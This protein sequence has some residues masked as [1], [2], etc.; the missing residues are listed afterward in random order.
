MA[1]TTLLETARQCERLGVSTSE[2]ASQAPLDA[3]LPMDS[4]DSSVSAALLPGAAGVAGAPAGARPAAAAP[5][6]AADACSPRPR[7]G[8]IDVS[9]MFSVEGTARH[10]S[11]LISPSTLG[12]AG[13]PSG[14]TDVAA[15]LGSPR[16]PLPQQ[17]QE[18]QQQQQ[19]RQQQQQQQ[20]GAAPSPEQQQERQQ[21][22]GVHASGLPLV[23]SPVDA[24]AYFSLEGATRE[25]GTLRY[26]PAT[27]AGSGCLCAC[28]PACLAG[29]LLALACRCP[30]G[31]SA[32][33]S[34]SLHNWSAAPSS[35]RPQVV[36]RAVCGRAWRGVPVRRLP[37][38]QPVPLCWPDS[39]PGRRRQRER[40][41]HARR[42]AGA[43]GW[44][45][46]VTA[47]AARD[48]SVCHPSS[49]APQPITRP[50]SPLLLPNPAVQLQPAWL[51]A[52]A[53]L[54]GG[55]RGGAAR[56]AAR[57][58]PPGALA[59]RRELDAPAADP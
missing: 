45:P 49:T 7:R 33:C 15:Y 27:E 34:A 26:A 42:A 24:A 43:G 25:Q 22:S 11:E 6:P 50:L 41:R 29:R 8:S 55:A 28:L 58:R 54:G 17:L 31:S 36:G 44:L 57:G 10:M 20:N 39:A 14:A 47:D 5:P 51:R 30:A 3:L 21:T 48:A 23:S 9:G 19:Q 2:G 35:T 12:S 59:A 37:A 32:A 46:H 38:A 56:A 1:P 13:L 52:A 40:R 16:H 18:Q 53:G 4:A